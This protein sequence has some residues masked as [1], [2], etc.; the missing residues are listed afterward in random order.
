MDINALPDIIANTPSYR[1][2]FPDD[3]DLFQPSFEEE[4]QVAIAQLKVG[5]A[6]GADGISAKLL[7]LREGKSTRW[8][9]SLFNSIWSSESVPLDWLN[10]PIAPLHKNGSRS[11][12]DLSIP[13]KFFAHAILNRTNPEP[14]LS[15]MRTSV[16]SARVEGELIKSFSLVCGPG[17]RK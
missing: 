17:L 9:T 13:S 11:E 3:E 10:H 5:K 7:K 6:S 15:C 12:C 4:L 16:V 14:R 1:E 2:L 8:L